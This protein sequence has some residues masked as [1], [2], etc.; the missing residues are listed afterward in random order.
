[1]DGDGNDGHL[2][3]LAM[4][5]DVKEWGG[6]GGGCHFRT[7][8]LILHSEVANDDNNCGAPMMMMMAMMG[9]MT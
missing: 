1:M 8:G 5:A 2:C 3:R 9:I 4:R 6:G 7:H